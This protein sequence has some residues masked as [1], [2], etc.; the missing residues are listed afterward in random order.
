SEPSAPIAKPSQPRPPSVIILQ[1]GSLLTPSYQSSHQRMAVL[2]SRIYLL[3]P[4]AAAHPIRP[5]RNSCNYSYR[6]SLTANSACS[7]DWQPLHRCRSLRKYPSQQIAPQSPHGQRMI[8]P[9]R[10]PPRFGLDT[11]NGCRR[12]R[13]S[14]HRSPDWRAKGSLNVQAAKPVARAPHSPDLRMR[15]CP[16]VRQLEEYTVVTVT[17]CLDRIAR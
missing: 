5:C 6:A 1:V 4:S 16:F 3:S 11:S 14:C 7:T 9:S 2:S 10:I 17:D 8:W 13:G 15:R 12:H